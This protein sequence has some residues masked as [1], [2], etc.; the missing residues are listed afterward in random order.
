[1][2]YKTLILRTF[3]AMGKEKRQTVEVSFFE[4]VRRNSRILSKLPRKRTH[5]LGS[6]KFPLA[7]SFTN[8]SVTYYRSETFEIHQVS[9]HG[10]LIYKT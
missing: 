3:M 2:E 6:M 5:R 10:S 8:K 7:T 4:I 1:M 9:P